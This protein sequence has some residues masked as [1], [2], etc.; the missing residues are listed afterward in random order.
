M[1]TI[2]HD[3]SEPVPKSRLADIILHGRPPGPSYDPFPLRLLADVYEFLFR[4]AEG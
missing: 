2:L 4:P 3:F 1:N